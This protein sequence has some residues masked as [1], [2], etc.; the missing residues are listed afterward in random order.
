MRKR[1]HD[2]GG[3]WPSDTLVW[4]HQCELTDFVADTWVRQFLQCD[5]RIPNSRIVCEA[6]EEMNGWIA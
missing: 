3:S 6:L 5:E 4:W 1:C 2:E